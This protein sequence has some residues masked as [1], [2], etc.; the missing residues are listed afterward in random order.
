MIECVEHPV[1]YEKQHFDLNK[2]KELGFKSK[3]DAAIWSNNSCGIA[4]LLMAIKYFRK[5]NSLQLSELLFEGLKYNYY[6]STKGWLHKGLGEL[7]KKYRLNYQ[8][9]GGNFN[10]D[11]IL[12]SLN[13]KRLVIASIA[14]KFPSNGN[15]SGHLIL[16]NGYVYVENKIQLIIQDPSKWGRDNHIIDQDVFIRNF[17]GNVIVLWN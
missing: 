8:L 1:I 16:I 4:C 11:V 7:S 2:Y 6:D 17:S 9:S 3:K 5:A 15:K 12:D 14:H 10:I 13:N